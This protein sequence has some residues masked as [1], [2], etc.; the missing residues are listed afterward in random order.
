MDAFTP[1]PAVDPTT[2]F[3]PVPVVYRRDG[4]TVERQRAFIATLSET[5]NV[6]AAA[7]GVGM[8][9]RSAYRLRVRPDAEAFAEAWDAALQLASH[10]L[11]ATAFELAVKGHERRLYHKGEFVGV[12]HVKSERLLMFLLR[13]YHPM[14]FGALSGVLDFSPRD[15]HGDVGRDLARLGGALVDLPAAPD[16]E[17]AVYDR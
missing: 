5:G 13:G 8:S 2:D 7:N 17:D 15:P 14:R 9:E 10:R 3:A 4:W 16:P 12:D 6:Y 1:P 11:L